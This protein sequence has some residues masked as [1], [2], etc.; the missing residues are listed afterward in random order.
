MK[1]GASTPAL[2]DS[3][4]RALAS[5][6]RA[7]STDAICRRIRENGGSPLQVTAA[8]IFARGKQAADVL[9]LRRLWAEFAAPGRGWQRK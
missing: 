5:E 9:T 6:G 1:V 8:L 2:F 3:A 4:R 7:P